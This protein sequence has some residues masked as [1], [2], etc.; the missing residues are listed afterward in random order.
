MTRRRHHLHF[1]VM[2]AASST[3]SSGG[4]ATG[5]DRRRAPRGV[6]GRAGRAPAATPAPTSR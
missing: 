5:S 3:R 2:I 1:S 6:E 4:T